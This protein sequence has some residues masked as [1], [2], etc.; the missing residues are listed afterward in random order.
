MALIFLISAISTAGV[1]L[2]YQYCIQQGQIFDFM[3]KPLV[4][5]QPRSE[6]WYKRLGG[7]AMCNMQLFSDV[8]YWTLALTI[9]DLAWYYLIF[10]WVMF[11]GCALWF[12]FL[13][14]YLI[15]KD[16]PAP[17]QFKTETEKIDL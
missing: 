7:C 5:L 11:S 15:K 17:T 3:Q 9:T 12:Y 2:L 10:W 1:A 14:S 8:I 6:F 13:A 4:W 16:Q